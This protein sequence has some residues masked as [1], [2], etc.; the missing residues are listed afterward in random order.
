MSQLR[1]VDVQKNLINVF[2]DYFTIIKYFMCITSRHNLV[3]YMRYI[4]NFTLICVVIAYKLH[5][6]HKTVK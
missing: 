1:W 4:K 2:Y 6:I 5:K 3:Y